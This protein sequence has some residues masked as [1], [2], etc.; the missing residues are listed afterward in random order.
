MEIL[1]IIPARYQSTRFPGKPLAQLGEKTVIQWVYDQSRKVL[2]EVYI[3]TDDRRIYS[4]VTDF[5]GN[6]IM[7]SDRHP[8]GTDRCR[9]AMDS[10]VAGT[11]LQPEVVIN[12]QGDEPFIDPRQI[13]LLITCFEDDQTDIATLVKA[14]EN[15]EEIFDENKPLVV[16]DHNNFAMYFS[17]SPIPFIRGSEQ[18]NW[19]T[20]HNFYRHIGIYAYRRNILQEITRLP[21]SNLEAAEALEQLRWLENGYRIKVAETDFHSIGIDTPADLKKAQQIL[22]KK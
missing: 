2:N 4:H 7:T 17:R 18:K 15:S 19:L 10:I 21:L 16:Y 22:E 1:G 5:G 13:E 6:V 12:I 11:G 9:E 20:A 8:S 3:A 14:V